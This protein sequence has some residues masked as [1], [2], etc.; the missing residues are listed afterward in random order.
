MKQP[1]RIGRNTFVNLWFNIHIPAQSD[2]W[3]VNPGGLRHNMMVRVADRAKRCLRRLNTC[4]AR[5]LL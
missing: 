2:S 1:S 3:L 4:F 5:I